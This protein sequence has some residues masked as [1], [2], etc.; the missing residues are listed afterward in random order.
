[1]F[2]MV[3]VSDLVHYNNP[4]LHQ[5]KKKFLG[6]IF[7][8]TKFPY[9]EFHSFNQA[10]GWFLHGFW[11]K[12]KRKKS[13]LEINVGPISKYWRWI[14]GSSS[15]S[16]EELLSCLCANIF[17][18]KQA[19]YYPYNCFSVKM[20]IMTNNVRKQRN[21]SHPASIFYSIF[22]N[23]QLVPPRLMHQLSQK[24]TCRS[25]KT[26]EGFDNTTEPVF[27]LFSKLT[28]ESQKHTL[29]DSNV[30]HP[31]AEIL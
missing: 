6:N 11:Q 13:N 29:E 20:Q 31:F 17:L 24:L 1:M 25:L 22:T 5:C 28:C 23:L 3:L 21:F 19:T 10:P 26:T 18:S 8:N 27:S 4:L 2:F 15:V 12:K 9:E 7:D 16:S 30:W 14:R